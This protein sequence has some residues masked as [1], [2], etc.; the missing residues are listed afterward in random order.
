MI[1]DFGESMEAYSVTRERH[2]T[3]SLYC[4]CFPSQ[5]V[6]A[7]ERIMILIEFHRGT[8]TS[9]AATNYLLV[10]FVLLDFSFKPIAY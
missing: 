2:L 4:Q 9:S 1:I 8:L 10:V 6:I 7:S 3:S 5:Y